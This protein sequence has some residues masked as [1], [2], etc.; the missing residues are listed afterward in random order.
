MPPL[1]EA[2]ELKVPEGLPACSITHPSEQAAL[3]IAEFNPE[4][5]PLVTISAVLA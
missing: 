4:E 3:L 5:V 1:P 2:R